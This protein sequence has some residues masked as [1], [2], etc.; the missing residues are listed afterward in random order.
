LKIGRLAPHAASADEV[1]RLLKAIRRN[2]ID[3]RVTNIS[4]ENRFD[5]AY[6]AI[7]Q[8]AMVAMLGNGYRHSSNEPGHHATLIQALPWTLGLPDKR[9]IVLDALRKKRNLS[10]YMGVDIDES[11]VSECIDEAEGL[12][13]DLNHWLKKSK[14]QLLSAK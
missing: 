3:A 13:R 9:W 8:T 11:L 5:A 4:P 10:D 12:L 6:K 1:Q 14:P 2:L 7:M